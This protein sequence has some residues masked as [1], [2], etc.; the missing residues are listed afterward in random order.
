[1]KNYAEW[2]LKNGRFV[3]NAE[4]ITA[5]KKVFKKLKFSRPMTIL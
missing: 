4:K 3:K 5:V 1:V 2:L